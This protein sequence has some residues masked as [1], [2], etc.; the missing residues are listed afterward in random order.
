MRKQ[1]STHSP[2]EP[3]SKIVKLSHYQ[4][5]VQRVGPN[6]YHFIP[7]NFDHLPNVHP[8]IA[9]DNSYWLLQCKPE[10]LEGYIV[11]LSKKIDT[12]DLESMDHFYAR[13]AKNSASPLQCEP[14]KAYHKPSEFIL[15]RGK[16]QQAVDSLEQGKFHHHSYKRGTF[17]DFLAGVWWGDHFNN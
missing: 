9:I 14:V 8:F 6:L 11:S 3:M 12:M 16:R 5:K 13:L 1:A 2:K 15:A 17:W 4:F 10:E 7:I